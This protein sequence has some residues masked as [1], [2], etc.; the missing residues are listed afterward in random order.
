M[1]LGSTRDLSGLKPVLKDPNSFGPDPVYWV[2]SEVTEGRPEQSEGSKSWAN[3]T[4]IAPGKIG[5][6]Y[7][8]TFGHYHGTDVDEVYH[9]IEGEGVLLLQKKFIDENG[10]WIK[11]KVE[12]VVLIKA[13]PGDEVVITPEWGHS[14]SNIGKGPLLSFDNWRAGHSPTDYSDIEALQGLAYYLVEE[15]GKVTA[16]AN[17]NYIDLPG[18]KW[19]SAE[20]FTKSL[21][22]PS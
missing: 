17:P 20:E 4:V 18:P 5:E 6:E 13:K 3:V 15:A 16:V 22:F 7:P 1:K 19:M 12:E 2:F 9:L 10:N 21:L 11:E 14:W 8:K